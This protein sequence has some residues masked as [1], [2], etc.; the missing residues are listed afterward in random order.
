MANNVVK[1]NDWVATML[2]NPDQSINS[3]ID[4]GLN[5]QNTV[6]ASK[7]DYRG[8]KKIQE[9]F[10]DKNGKFNEKDFEKFYD[11]ANDSYNQLSIESFNNEATVQRSFYENQMGAPKD[12]QK[13]SLI[14]R[15]EKVQNPMKNIIGM[16]G[17]N[18]V[19]PND[20]SV[21]EIAQEN[22]VRDSKT[23]KSLG[24]KPNDDNRS[25]FFDFL[26]NTDPTVLAQWDSDGEHI[27]PFSKRKIKHQ[28]GEQKTDENGDFYY[29]TLGNREAF[30]K[31]FLTMQDTFTDDGSFANKFD[32]MDSDGLT[33]SITG[34][35]MKTA[36]SIVPYFIPKVKYLYPILTTAIEAA[37]ALPSLVKSIAGFTGNDLSK[38]ERL[39]SIQGQARR[40]KANTEVSDMSQQK[41]FSFENMMNI[42]SSTVDQLYS[43]RLVAQ[44]PGMLGSSNK[45]IGKYM[46]ELDTLSK[47]EGDKKFVDMAEDAQKGILAKYAKT[48]KTIADLQKKQEF[49]NT[50]AATNLSS[51]YMAAT[52][53][54]QAYEDAK[55]QG[56]NQQDASRYYTGVFAGMFSLMRY[57][58]IGHWAL[59]GLGTDDVS[60][61]LNSA[62]KTEGQ[63]VLQN[64]KKAN[65]A[66]AEDI[67][68]NAPKKVGN[69]LLNVFNAGLD[70]GKKAGNILIK[71]D[72]DTL[73]KASAAEGIEEMSEELM[74]DTFKNVYN[75]L[76][77]IGSTKTKKG[78]QFQFTADDIMKRYAMSFIGGAV[79]GAIFKGSE[80]LLNKTSQVV[81]ENVNKD[82]LWHISNGNSQKLLDKIDDIESKGLFGSTTLTPNAI[83]ST[84]Y[85]FDHQ[86]FEPTN[87]KTKSQNAFIANIL[88]AKV[89][90]LQTVVNQYDIPSQIALG[91]DYS[92]R[93]NR[94]IDIKLNSS[95]SEDVEK[96]SNDIYENVAEIRALERPTN[97]SSEADVKSFHEQEKKYQDRIKDAREELKAISKGDRL[98]KYFEEAFFS[99]R[100]FLYNQFDVKTPN[101]FAE[102]HY[103]KKYVEL[104][105]EEK[106]KI[107]SIYE[108]YASFS[109]LDHLKLGK[110]Q[111]DQ[112]KEFILKNK[113]NLSSY[114]G[115]KIVG[116]DEETIEEYKETFKKAKEPE[117]NF[118]D[119]VNNYNEQLS[120]GVNPTQ[121]PFSIDLKALDNAVD[122]QFEKDN[123]GHLKNIKF[124]RDLNKTYLI[125]KYKGQTDILSEQDISGLKD[126]IKVGSLVSKTNVMAF[127][128][129]V[130]KA[131][132]NKKFIELNQQDIDSWAQNGVD[133][134][135]IKQ[136]QESFDN[137]DEII[138]EANKITNKLSEDKNKPSNLLNILK[139][140]S[141]TTAEKDENDVLFNV[142]DILDTQRKKM[143]NPS[144]D[145]GSFVINSKLNEDQ[146]DKSIDTINKVA[147]TIY[148]MSDIKGYGNE[149]FI[150]AVNDILK[151]NN[152]KSEYEG[153][154][155][156]QV[157]SNK[158]LNELYYYKNQLEFMKTVSKQNKGNK[159]RY[160][161][162]AS[163]TYK[164]KNILSFI[165]NDNFV[166]NSLY[167]DVFKNFDGKE[168]FF[169]SDEIKLE[170]DKFNSLLLQNNIEDYDDFSLSLSDEDIILLNETSFNIEKFIHDKINSSPDGKQKLLDK[171]K[172]SFTQK[173][174]L[175]DIRNSILS[176]IERAEQNPTKYNPKVEYYKKLDSVNHLLAIVSL[177]PKLMNSYIIGSTDA[178]GETDFEK[179]PYA[180]L[181]SQEDAIRYTASHV[182]SQNDE[183][184]IIKEFYSF[185]DKNH[186]DNSK[187]DTNRKDSF[188]YIF[189][190][191]TTIEGYPGTGK[192]TILNTISRILENGNKKIM[193]YAP[194]DKK[195]KELIDSLGNRDNIVK[196]KSNNIS[197]FTREI[198][199]NEL[200]SQLISAMKEKTWSEFNMK[201]IKTFPK[202]TDSPLIKVIGYNDK[203]EPSGYIFKLNESHPDVIKA[204]ENIKNIDADVIVI[205]EYT[206][207]NPVDFS[208]LQNFEKAYNSRQEKSINYVFVGD[209]LQQGFTMDI[210]KGGDNEK[211]MPSS[212]VS[213]KTPM[214]TDMLRAGYNNKIDDIMS[215][216]SLLQNVIDNIQDPSKTYSLIKD[217]NIKFSYSE[218]EE[219]GLIGEKIVDKIT[220]EDLMSLTK[221][222][223]VGVIVDSKDDQIVKMIESL[224]GVDQKHFDIRIQSEV[225]G[226]EFNNVVIATKEPP[227]NKNEKYSGRNALKSLYTYISRSK[228]GSL[229]L[230]SAIADGLNIS[231]IRGNDN[232]KAE[233]NEAQV[234]DYKKLRFDILKGSYDTEMLKA[235]KPS[236]SKIITET[237]GVKTMQK[238]NDDMLVSL[239]EQASDPSIYKPDQ[240]FDSEKPGSPS[241]FGKDKMYMY[242]FHE[243]KNHSMIKIENNDTIVYDY[244]NPTDDI[245]LMFSNSVGDPKDFVDSILKNGEKEVLD[246]YKQ[247]FKIIK[248]AILNKIL[249]HK[250]E[251][252][253][254][255]IPKYI[256]SKYSNID[257]DS[258]DTVIESRELNKYNYDLHIDQSSVYKG[259]Q[260]FDESKVNLIH[261]L[262][263][264]LKTKDGKNLFFTISSFPNINNPEV[265]KQPH[266]LKFIQESLNMINGNP[267]EGVLFRNLGDES[268]VNDISKLTRIK[269]APYEKAITL[270][271]FEKENKH[272]VYSE[273]M[274]I[275]KEY[276]FLEDSEESE[277]GK[278]KSSLKGKPVMFV[279]FDQTLKPYEL[280]QEYINQLKEYNE[281]TRTDFSVNIAFITTRQLPFSEWIQQYHDY[282]KQPDSA[283]KNSYENHFMAAKLLTNM[284]TQANYY[285][286]LFDQQKNG[287]ISAEQKIRLDKFINGED[288]LSKD[289]VNQIIERTNSLFPEINTYLIDI[290]KQKEKGD[291]ESSRQ[292]TLNYVIGKIQESYSSTDLNKSSLAEYLKGVIG[293]P[294][295]KRMFTDINNAKSFKYTSIIHSILYNKTTSPNEITDSG[296]FITTNLASQLNTLISY[297]DQ[298]KN[299]MVYIHPTIEKSTSRSVEVPYMCKMANK[300]SDI[301]I[302][303]EILPP[304]IYINMSG[305][306]NVDINEDDLNKQKSI[307]E[308]KEYVKL[309][310]VDE[311]M[312]KLIDQI[313][314]NY[315]KSIEEIKK[316]IINNLNKKFLSYQNKYAYELNF[317]IES[318]NG[319]D[320]IINDI[321]YIKNDELNITIN[322]KSKVFD[323]L[324][325]EIKLEGDNIVAIKQNGNE[326]V[327][328][329]TGNIV[330]ERI[331]KESTDITENNKI[332]TI[333]AS[334]IKSIV[335]EENITDDIKKEM[336]IEASKSI[337]LP[338]EQFVNKLNEILNNNGL[339]HRFR[340]F[341][342]D[343]EYNLYETKINEQV[344]GVENKDK[345]LPIVS[346]EVIVLPSQPILS[347]AD[348]LQSFRDSL[349]HILGGIEDY[350]NNIYNQ[351]N[352]STHTLQDNLSKIDSIL[353]DKNFINE[354]NKLQTEDKVLL[355]NALNNLFNQLKC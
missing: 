149:T 131:D 128:D 117:A 82:M 314:I 12:V 185:L 331:S 74:Q 73:L 290:N 254:D 46:K 337:N 346:S 218:S 55:R 103:N 108:N 236:T 183:F 184:N 36:A 162:V 350:I 336:Q 351:F 106:D 110:K 316:D 124:L 180:P 29:E 93:V 232:S 61:T 205:D 118:L 204:F 221:D 51:L 2:S 53:S 38:N 31:Q 249:Y 15:F 273:P 120:L 75:G 97:D 238:W 265:Q 212:V 298:F 203:G 127:N 10:T 234:K 175:E 198:M 304:N 202:E 207:I 96:L 195:G 54:T 111:F 81:P 284:I 267:V 293:E 4:S 214:L 35:V 8:T 6:M 141:L 246:E 123:Q 252:L 235:I 217:N 328:D 151:R 345:E 341:E 274:I 150:T 164:S 52:S 98:Q 170:I 199:G 135:I 109:K 251:S 296:K 320:W 140:I 280:E 41:A 86:N 78:N 156:T 253:M 258:F 323:G 208:I 302:N 266:V 209:S 69:K 88:R 47:I 260:K 313:G 244:E 122:E 70:L 42:V 213:Y 241:E 169:D 144:F 107:D 333:F 91:K 153:K 22:F 45:Q 7:D 223:I 342:K 308:K 339:G 25:G 179:T 255:L 190:N 19:S 325:S 191:A 64:L 76:N 62:I 194:Y 285:K 301:I 245:A 17:I 233:F 239:Y 178:N 77:S 9:L 50:T 99:T 229:I 84:N 287:K 230:K 85:D 279:S 277:S 275:T 319:K 136:L 338:I 200:Y 193:A 134:G 263:L 83:Y 63:G 327:I 14:G 216:Q 132:I 353:S 30:D 219:D 160:D 158:L 71:G 276:D 26:F 60:K 321:I 92:D 152:I 115:N 299:G 288:S 37:D 168:D 34:T 192:S 306:S 48:S 355:F 172:Q 240:I 335:D 21:R 163:N 220:I 125:Q 1:G 326:L 307:E 171:I 174:D 324:F 196:T 187:I 145:L 281:G 95:L 340:I 210:D 119:L 72:I 344:E 330:Q 349:A 139:N 237:S 222:G 259:K 257:F 89:N 146:I 59:K 332:L 166:F 224:P 283:M 137:R 247:D 248:T 57:T 291:R 39:N 227:I 143:N 116:L 243:R 101:D 303:K 348:A 286:Y 167:D 44:I 43:Q 13:R 159:I 27:D 278:I 40:L 66:Y 182:M 161:K 311:D 206:H 90:Q 317:R 3:L 305:L 165:P 282:K 154:N 181:Q 318:S 142:F 188:Q 130:K 20:K 312:S 49:W 211:L 197:D 16:Q 270:E 87:D 228:K 215:V 289:L 121:T 272:I 68:Q 189:S 58:E 264:R 334:K 114:I 155:F 65:S 297:G 250:D 354:I 11:Q 268:K 231:S 133:P 100:P 157:E 104:N 56:L 94:I 147:A 271:Q 261:F 352:E 315:N 138:N 67:L 242:P 32:F 329:K 129:F 113:E 256:L 23:G 28:K 112:Y 343:G 292:R 347:R 5:S 80:N 295:V 102:T 176:D 226:G 201:D 310:S 186:F 322:N 225:Q 309:L 18:V 105:D 300:K 177:D 24:W 173:T 148:S 262:D 269:F 294:E 33:K 79:G 126:N